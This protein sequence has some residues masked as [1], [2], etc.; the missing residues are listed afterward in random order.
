M[1]AK[2]VKR[3]RHKKAKWMASLKDHP[4]MDCSVQYPHYVMDW[5]HVHGDKEFELGDARRDNTSRVRIL[6]EIEKC[7]LVCSNCHRIRHRKLNGYA[8]V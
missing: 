7:E 6:A 8:T 5:D 4:C 3:C 1:G 2:E